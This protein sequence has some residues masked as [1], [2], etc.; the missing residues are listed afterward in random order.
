MCFVLGV[1]GPSKCRWMYYESLV[2]LKE[3]Y[4]TLNFFFFHL[5]I[6]FVRVSDPVSITLLQLLY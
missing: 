2:Q 3:I 6:P 1:A 4:R 5:R